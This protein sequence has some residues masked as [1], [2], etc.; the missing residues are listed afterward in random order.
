METDSRRPYAGLCWRYVGG[1]T[2]AH[3]VARERDDMQSAM[4]STLFNFICPYSK[5]LNSEK[6]LL[7]GNSPK[8]EVVEEL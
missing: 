1:R 6:C 7:S 2:G 4:A 3:A 8:I 5:M